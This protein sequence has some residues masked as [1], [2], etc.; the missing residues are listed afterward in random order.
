MITSDSDEIIPFFL[1]NLQNMISINN[2]LSSSSKEETSSSSFGDISSKQNPVLK[3]MMVST[4][5]YQTT[6]YSKVSY[7]LLKQLS[8]ECDS[9]K[10]QIIHYAIQGQ[11]HLSTD[12]KYPSNVTV[13]DALELENPKTAG[14]GINELP[15]I[16]RK[17][18]P[19]IVFIYNDLAVVSSYINV[20]KTEFKTDRNFKIWVYV[21]QVYECQPPLFINI[22]NTETD[23]LFCFTN[24]W[25]DILKKQGI[26]RPIDVIPHGFDSTIFHKIDSK[27]QL[28]EQ[29]GMPNDIFL[30]M[31]VN[32]NQPRKRLDVLIMAFVELITKHPH[33]PLFLM[34]VCDK[35]EKGGFPIFDI[36]KRELELK[37]ITNLDMF[38]N[39]LLV[40]STDLCYSDE[41]INMLYNVA[42]VGV[43]CVD[44]EGFGLC[45]FEQ[46]GVGVPQIVSNVVG[47]QEYCNQN[48]SIIIDDYVR[49]YLP[50]CHSPIGGEIKI[51]NY[52]SVA[53]A[54]EKYVL[55]PDLIKIHGENAINTVHKYTWNKCVFPLCQRLNLS[56]IEKQI[57]HK[58]T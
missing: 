8:S 9:T 49:C 29:I 7:N 13:Y 12:R 19:D 30:F 48:N 40:S 58:N 21:D 57:E 43:S 31:S 17:E 22:L 33:L 15:S 3:F 44:G 11:K 51:I 38:S 56:Y 37:G 50:N 25:R 16:I 28:R 1:Q 34:C 6:G 32:R 55:S 14:F 26:T 23:R 39:R 36:F 35:G 20:I 4:S 2:T 24:K 53:N 42:D 52:I 10:I 54:M 41:Q 47:H 18:S 46:M 27:K 5:I 45:V